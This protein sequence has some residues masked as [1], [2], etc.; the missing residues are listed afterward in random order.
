MKQGQLYHN[1]VTSLTNVVQILGFNFSASEPRDIASG[2]PTGKST[3]TPV[4]LYKE[5]DI[6]SPLLMQALTTNE[7]F[8]ATITAVDPATSQ[9]CYTLIGSVGLANAVL[10][11]LFGLR[12]LTF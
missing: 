10:L 8:Q 11:H 9:Y 6:S 1:N 7:I 5:M 2:L 4:S 3:F 12:I